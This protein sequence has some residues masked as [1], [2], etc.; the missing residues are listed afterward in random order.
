MDFH[1]PSFVLA[2][3]A[4]CTLGWVL[5]T[6]IRAHHGYP[7]TD[8]WGSTVGRSDPADTRRSELLAQDNE[9]LAGMV[10][11][12]EERIAVLE[13]IATDPARRL[14]AAIEQLK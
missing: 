7:I 3:I 11:R 4:I 6:A 12:L 9:R 13:R 8:D 14:S 5:T 10:G 1:S 2:I